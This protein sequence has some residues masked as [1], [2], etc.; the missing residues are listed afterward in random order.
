MFSTDNAGEVGEYPLSENYF[1]TDRY[2]YND[3]QGMEQILM[4]LIS[5][6]AQTFDKEVTSET[7][8]LLFPE[9]GA[10]F[11]GD[12]VARNIQR[13][14]DHLLPGFCCYYRYHEDS[15]FDCA[16]GWDTRYN[17]ISPENWQQLQTIY[18]CPSD[19]D[20]FTG[21]LAQEAYNGGLTGKVFL[22]MIRKFL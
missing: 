3:G 14:R 11:G 20:L 6:A 15:N 16:Q 13:G 1:N 2:Y 5:Q 8:N 10:D 21:G 19:I 7:T 17:S 12:L 18:D 9:D 22:E 4:G